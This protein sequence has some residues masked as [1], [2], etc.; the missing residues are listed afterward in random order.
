[1]SCV[2][3]TFDV[4]RA[5]GVPPGAHEG[6]SVSRWEVNLLFLPV[7]YECYSRSRPESQISHKRNR[8]RAA[9]WGW[10]GRETLAGDK[11]TR[12]SHP[13]L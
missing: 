7:G 1:M 11:T 3:S 6:L 10:G 8:G 13:K 9:P 2:S 5:K 12:V 4:S